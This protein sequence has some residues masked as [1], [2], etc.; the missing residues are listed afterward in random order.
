M[1]MKQMITVIGGLLGTA[2]L[3]AGPAAAGQGHYGHKV[4][5]HTPVIV[6][7]PDQL[8]YEHFMTPAVF[9]IAKEKII[10]KEGVWGKA[11]CHARSWR[12]ASSNTHWPIGTI[13]PVS[14]AMA[15][16]SFGTTRPRAGWCQR[17]SA[18]KPV[19]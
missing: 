5:V 8:C 17:N 15:I 16:N 9:G 12:H 3:F 7:Q 10:V 14:S 4:L 11:S 19:I 6:H 18:S 2:A 13:K 1:S